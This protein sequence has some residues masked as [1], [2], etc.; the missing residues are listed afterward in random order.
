VALGLNPEGT[1]VGGPVTLEG[2]TIQ[3]NSAGATG[4]GR[5]GGLYVSRS[6][7]R[8]TDIFTVTRNLIA[9]NVASQGG[10]SRG[11][12]V[13]LGASH[14]ARFDANTIIGNRATL[15][16][17]AQATSL[18]TERRILSGT[19][20]S[21]RSAT[22]SE[23][24]SFMGDEIASG[25]TSPLAMTV[26]A[27]TTSLGGGVYIV[28][29][30]EFSL[31]NN[32]VARN[33]ATQGSGL[34]LGGNL[35]NPYDA[36]A[37]WGRFLYTTVADNVGGAGAWL[38][39]P[40]RAGTVTDAYSGGVQVL[41]SATGFYRVGDTLLFIHTDG[42]TRATR[43]L[44]ALEYLGSKARLTLDSALP[45]PYPAGSMV[46][47]APAM[48]VN[49]IVA[50]QTIGI[51]AADQ[52]VTLANS[53][54]HGNGANTSDNLNVIL[55][56]GGRDR[57]SGIRRPR[58]GGLPHRQR[59]GGARSGKRHRGPHRSGRPAAALRRG[60]RH[61]RGRVHAGGAGHR[62]ADPHRHGDGHAHAH[63]ERDSL[64]DGDADAHVNRHRHR[65]GQP[66]PPAGLSAA[67]VEA[68][69]ILQ[70]PVFS[71]K[72]GFWRSFTSH[73]RNPWLPKQ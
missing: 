72:M 1:A 38:E 30:H 16:G 5:G 51:G 71:A 29:S 50:G 25:S 27:A 39:S 41:A 36:F 19:Q 34:W 13:Y 65:H 45:T 35:D 12:G 8:P 3:G 6:T 49:T 44:T 55:T 33:Q 58:G 10:A 21:R 54:W 66:G 20:W 60:V 63:A 73:T 57:R 46:R 22:R 18:R 47:D 64:P 24:I 62:H 69:S 17:M 67:G 61:R 31:T 4:D 2:N 28:N 23:A 37:A 42:V 7:D 26:S 68:V 40:L 14:Q 43:R 32:V 56:P 53:L 11:G 52:A 9:E 48:F 15:T 70:K 59:L